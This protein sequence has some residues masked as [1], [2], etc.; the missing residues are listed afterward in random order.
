MVARGQAPLGLLS[1]LIAEQRL[2]DGEMSEIEQEYA[3]NSAAL[4][5]TM[6]AISSLAE[7]LMASSEPLALTP[8]LQ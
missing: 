7:P 3:H 5:P 1:S 2:H 4:V 8:G 6:K